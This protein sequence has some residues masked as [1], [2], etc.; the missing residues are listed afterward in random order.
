MVR[1]E[2]LKMEKREQML[3]LIKKA[4]EEWNETWTLGQMEYDEQ[5]NEIIVWVGRTDVYKAWFDADTLKCNGTK[6]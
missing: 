5:Y 3:K 4:K 2:R 1:K 6:C